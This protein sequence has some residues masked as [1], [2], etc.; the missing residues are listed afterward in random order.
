VLDNRLNYGYSGVKATALTSQCSDRLV[1]LSQPKKIS[2]DYIDAYILPKSVSEQSLHAEVSS[3]VCELAKPR[4][5][6]IILQSAWKIK[7]K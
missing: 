6:I 1:T 4:R 5:N 7:H 3:R 2:K